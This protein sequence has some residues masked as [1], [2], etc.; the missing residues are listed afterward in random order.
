MPFC[1]YT[2]G[3]IMLWLKFRKSKYAHYSIRVDPGKKNNNFNWQKKMLQNYILY[4]QLKL[5]SQT[6]ILI[7][8]DENNFHQLNLL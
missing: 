3:S 2:I 7:L 4:F 6:K 8:N 5:E 1:N